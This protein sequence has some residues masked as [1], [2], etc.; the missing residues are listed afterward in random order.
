MRQ[1]GL[2]R[3]LWISVL[4]VMTNCTEKKEFRAGFLHPSEN[5]QRF[6]KEANFFAERIRELGGEAVIAAAND[7]EMVQL[8]QGYKMLDEGVDILVVSAVNGVTIGSLVRKAK[9]KGIPVVAYLRLIQNVDYDAF[10]TCDNMYMAET[11]C[12]TALKRFPE[13]NYVVIAG[14][15]GDRN[16]VEEKN[17]IDKVL[18]PYIT[19][20]KINVVYKNYMEN[21]SG[22]DASFE[23]EKVMKSYQ[24]DIQAVI[25]C[26]DD[27]AAGVIE[28]LKK[29]GMEGK[30]FTSG[31][32]ADIIGIHNIQRGFQD[33]TFYHP[34]NTLGRTT[35]DVAY[36]VLMNNGKNNFS[37]NSY[38]GLANIPTI[39]IRSIPITKENISLL[40][41]E[42]LYA[43][44]KLLN[45]N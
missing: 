32:D 42:G 36:N 14:D 4:V 7:D 6:V 5:R 8:E 12:Q 31:Q 13:G 10:V 9:D 29:Y 41:Q 43:Q 40:V 24:N 19:S 39:R 21:W 45:I 2:S 33:L 25:S 26:N 17:G 11:W 37:E 27:M 34:N 23:F 22:E 20:G 18:E 16:A 1:V 30:V 28:V 35:A 3:L 38:N 44:D 15:Y